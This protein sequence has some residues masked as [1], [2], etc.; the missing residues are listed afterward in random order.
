MKKQTIFAVL[1]MTLG[2]GVG[3]PELPGR[4]QNANSQ[5]M[6]AWQDSFRLEGCAF[7]VT[8]RNPYFILEPGY[9]LILEGKDGQKAIQLEITVLNETK[10]VG[11]IETRVVEEKETADGQ[12]TEI[13]RNY[14]AVCGPT[15]DIFYFGEDV[16]IYG[17]GKVVS[18]EGTWIAYQGKNRPGLLIPGAA[19]VGAK[20]YQEVAPTVAMDRAEVISLTESL[21]TPAGLF[22]GCLKTQET[23]PLEPEAKEYKIYAPGVGLIKDGDLL[24]TKINKIPQ[25]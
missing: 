14:F 19:K 9:Q 6:S 2:L 10:K 15:N 11:S 17:N 5:S 13:S 18:H 22:K 25:K 20:Y 4:A 1:L 3:F 23:T 24:L 16:D 21:Q 8:G 7:S 12:L